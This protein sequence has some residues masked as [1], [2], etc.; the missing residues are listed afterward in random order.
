MVGAA[1]E[2]LELFAGSRQPRG[3]DD[4]KLRH[5]DHAQVLLVRYLVEHA[6]GMLEKILKRPEIKQELEKAL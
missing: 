3:K 4:D 2:G 6:P 5:A 1:G